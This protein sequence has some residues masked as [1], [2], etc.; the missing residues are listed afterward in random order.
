MEKD[1]EYIIVES[2]IPEVNR[3]YHGDVHIRPVE[4]QEPYSIDMHV[5]CP[6]ELKDDYPVGTR[7]RIKAKITSR[8]GGK[9]FAH[10]H[11]TWPY[12]VL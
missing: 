1:Y 9:L 2:Y 12:E 7:F 10:S 8:E 4:G 5:R 3:G 6:E 11:Y